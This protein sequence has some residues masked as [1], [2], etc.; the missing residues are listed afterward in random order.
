[1]FTSLSLFAL[2]GLLCATSPAQASADPDAPTTRVAHG[3]PVKSCGFAPVILGPRQC[4]A[5]LVHPKLVICAAHCGAQIQ[6]VTFGESSTRPGRRAA[7][8]YCKTHP[9]HPNNEGTDWSFCVLKEAV[10]DIPVIPPAFGCELKDFMKVGQKVTQ[11]GFGANQG[12]HGQTTGG[13]IKRWGENKVTEM[14]FTHAD[15]IKVGPN[16]KNVVACPGDSGGPLLIRMKDGSWRTMA[17]AS[18]YSGNCGAETPFN[19]YARIGKA[20]SWIE[21]ES[22]I[23]ITP[24]FDSDGTWNPTKECKGFYAGD[25]SAQGSWN[26]GCKEAPKSGY[27]STCGEPFGGAPKL[28]ISIEAPKDKATIITKELPA[29][30]SIKAKLDKDAPEQ[31]TL[32]IVVDGKEIEDS[33]KQKA[34]W[35]F[36]HELDEGEHKLALW[37]D[38]GKQKR[39]QTKAISVTVEAET[40]DESPEPSNDGP[41][42]KDPSGKDPSSKDPSDKDPSGKDPSS[43]EPSES[44]PG[45]PE[46]SDESPKEGSTEPESGASK[47]GE[48]PD[49]GDTGS[50]SGDTSPKLEDATPAPAKSGC[51]LQDQGKPGLMGLMMLGLLALKRRRSK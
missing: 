35:T 7:V 41:S 23:D 15:N 49:S 12:K 1:M 33:G 26:T 20:V 19:I 5:T 47:S 22:G 45:S 8:E 43:Q 28:D 16:S 4:S 17:I 9:G 48:S 46:P 36:E 10:T 40:P 25:A 32:G 38:I 29:K 42:G 2:P 6:S 30:V 14:A 50:S 39:K 51:S 27:S 24:C 37:Y 3:Q 21:K 31:F 11:V 44:D 18:R 34:P 13:G